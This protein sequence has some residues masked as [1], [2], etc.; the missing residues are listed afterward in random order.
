[1]DFV[2]LLETSH[3]GSYIYTSTERQ[4][5]MDTQTSTRTHAPNKPWSER[6]SSLLAANIAVTSPVMKSALAVGQAGI[7]KR[8][9]GDS[10]WH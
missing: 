7:W 1:M 6:S 4:M 10:D 2:F 5:E 8:S 3:S 9:H